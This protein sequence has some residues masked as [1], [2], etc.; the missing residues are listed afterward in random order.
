MVERVEPKAYPLRLLLSRRKGFY[1][2]GLSRATNG[3]PAVICT[4]PGFYGN[5][6]PT[7]AEFEA[8]INSR[9]T[10]QV[11]YKGRLISSWE[12][13]ERINFLCGKNLLAGAP[14]TTS[15]RVGK[16]EFGGHAQRSKS[17]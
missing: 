8:W 9:R 6:F 13:C 12:T 7:A 17:V 15:R 10:L 16:G 3:L 14:G 11:K 1:L 5:P 2:Q 4:R